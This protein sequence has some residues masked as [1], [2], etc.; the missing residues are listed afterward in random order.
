MAFKERVKNVQKELTRQKCDALLVDDSVNLYYLT[1]MQLSE[2]KLVVHKK[3]AHLLVDN[4][5]YEL[6][7]K[8][9]PFL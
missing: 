2:G 4:R 9:C 5:Y 1:G 6:C 8:G 3:G 7:K